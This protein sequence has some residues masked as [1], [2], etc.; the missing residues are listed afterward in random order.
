MKGHSMLLLLGA[1]ALTTDTTEGNGPASINFGE[2]DPVTSTKYAVITKRRAPTKLQNAELACVLEVVIP[3]DAKTALSRAESLLITAYNKTVD[4]NWQ[5]L[6]RLRIDAVNS[7]INLL[8]E[9]QNSLQTSRA[10]RGWFDII[11]QFLHISTGVA[12]D[13]DINMFVISIS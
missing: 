7:S 2:R 12:T 11:G 13:K 9:T 3:R 4:Y 8:K 6:P 1:L 5:N 10:R